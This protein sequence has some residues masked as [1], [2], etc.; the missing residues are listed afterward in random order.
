MIHLRRSNWVAIADVFTQSNSQQNALKDRMKFEVTDSQT[1]SVH[2]QPLAA[3]L[4]FYLFKTHLI[5]LNKSFQSNIFP[6][7]AASV[8][9]C[10]CVCVCVCVWAG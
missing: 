3:S 7:Q 10:F 8:L 6:A 5:K 9:L 2:S 1:D 4:S